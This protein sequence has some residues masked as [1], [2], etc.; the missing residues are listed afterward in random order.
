MQVNYY[1]YYLSHI[2]IVR[3]HHQDQEENPCGMQ[4]NH[5]PIIHPSP[6]RINLP[7]DRRPQNPQKNPSD[8]TRSPPPP[9]TRT[10][11]NPPPKNP[12]LRRNKP[13]KP[14][15]N[16]PPIDPTRSKIPKRGMTKLHHQCKRKN[17]IKKKDSERQP[18]GVDDGDAEFAGGRNP[19]KKKETTNREESGVVE[20]GDGFI[21]QDFH[22][23]WLG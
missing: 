21:S 17:S 22:G 8:Q 18:S 16:S 23:W 2:P 3:L 5:A 4:G 9:R 15:R 6:H 1:Y 14:D 20:V 13:N 19:A 7:N 10:E 12:I 11:Q